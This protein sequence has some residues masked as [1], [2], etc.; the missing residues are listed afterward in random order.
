[1]KSETLYYIIIAIIAIVLGFSL[2][3]TF[4]NLTKVQTLQNILEFLLSLFGSSI[5]VFNYLKIKYGSKR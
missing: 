5:L 2:V 4:V 1:M 3:S